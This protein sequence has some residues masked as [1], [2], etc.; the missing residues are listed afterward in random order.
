MQKRYWKQL[1]AVTMTACLAVALMVTGCGDKK[2]LESSVN[3]NET[4]KTTVANEVDVSA[5][6]TPGVNVNLVGEYADEAIDAK[7]NLETSTIVEFNGTTAAVAGSGAS[8]ADGMVTISKEGTYVLSGAGDQIQ[9]VVD[10]GEGEDVQLVLNQVYLEHDETAPIYIKNGE[11]AFLTLADGTENSI[12][13]ARAAYVEPEDG[14]E[15]TYPEGEEPIEAAIYSEIDLVLNG[16]GKLMV[17]AGYDDGIRTKD[18]MEIISGTYHVTSQDDAFVGKDSISVRDGDITTLAK[19]TALKSNK[20][21][22]LEKGYV[23][24]DG[25]TFDLT[26]T[27]GDGMH[28]EFAL[29]IN[30]GDILIRECEEGLEAMNIIIN[31]GKIE[32]T[33]TDDGVNISEAEDYTATFGGGSMMEGADTAIDHI[34]GALI[35]NGGN[36]LVAASGDGLDSNGD[37][38]IAGG[39]TIVNGPTNSGNGTLDYADSFYMTGGVLAISGNQGMEQTISNT[40]LASVTAQLNTSGTA[41]TTVS[42]ADAKGTQMISFVAKNDFS[43]VSMTSA[44]L[45]EGESYTI[46][47][48]SASVTATAT[49]LQTSGM[50]G[51]LPGGQKP[52]GQRPDGQMPNG[53]MSPGQ[54]PEGDRGQMPENFEPTQMPDGVEPPQ[55]PN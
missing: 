17:E 20:S 38:L 2:Q 44:D 3:E 18:D 15:I 51:M 12:V 24:I 6:T 19:G 48:G 13:D 29:V 9:V 34:P 40:S 41:G 32:L 28:G 35:I 21:D 30:D 23:V 43:Y 26:A 25:G 49:V 10:A 55:M 5:L 39:T 54:R 8:F 46:T 33:S 42:I 22:D 50:G 27:E 4:T 11:N 37:I 1:L 47:A 36:L 53:Q 7:W 52:G 14:E 31:G 45:V 16:T